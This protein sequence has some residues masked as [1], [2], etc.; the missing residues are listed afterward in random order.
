MSTGAMVGKVTTACDGGCEGGI[1]GPC[2]ICFT[3]QT[4]PDPN[5]TWVKLRK[6]HVLI[7]LVHRM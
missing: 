2:V 4:E 5:K 7:C 1:W 3:K 6:T